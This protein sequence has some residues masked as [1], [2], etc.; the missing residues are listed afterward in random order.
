M[1]LLDLIYNNK[2][3]NIY[4]YYLSYKGNWKYGC[5][6]YGNNEYLNEDGVC[7]CNPKNTEFE[8][9]LL[10]FSDLYTDCKFCNNYLVDDENEQ[11]DNEKDFNSDAAYKEIKT[12]IQLKP[13]LLFIKNYMGLYPLDFMNLLYELL[14]I[15][16]NGTSNGHGT[17]YSLEIQKYLNKI[18]DDIELEY[19]NHELRKYVACKYIRNS[20]HIGTDATQL[21]LPLHIWKYIFTFI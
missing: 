7:H 12:L 5:L 4:K 20:N 19:F 6:A 2:Y 17:Y 15:K 11:D 21:Q 1:D 16:Y 3:N 18:A 9:L 13:E 10:C 14:N 8:K